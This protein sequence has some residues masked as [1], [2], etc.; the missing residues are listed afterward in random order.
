MTIR[1]RIAEL[2]AWVREG[3]YP[4]A[5]IADAGG[6]KRTTVLKAFEADW[7]PTAET[8][9]GVERAHALLVE[10]AGPHGLPATLKA[11]A[12]GPARAA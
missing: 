10:D 6:I 12:P 9:L 5:R 4:A 1:D 8:L 7:N 3:G 2:Q 11:A